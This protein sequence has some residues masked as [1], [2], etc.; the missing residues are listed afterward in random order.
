MTPEEKFNQ[1]VWWILQEIKK[2]ELLTLQGEMIDFSIRT[3]PKT[4]NVKQKDIDY[5]VPHEDTQR[6]LLY[7]LKEWKIIDD[8]EPIDDI[9]RGSDIFNPRIYKLFIAH[10]KFDEIYLCYKELNTK[11]KSNDNGA[12]LSLSAADRKKLCILEKL[13]EEW[14]LTPTETKISPIKHSQWQNEC[15]IT[16]YYEFKAILDF[17]KK[18]KLINSF[19]FMDESK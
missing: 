1:N 9:L 3:L 10:P 7:K 15:N 4:H 5:S 18:E 8:L 11:T 19:N 13:K 17:L 6:K 2:D 12:M 16:D 14:D